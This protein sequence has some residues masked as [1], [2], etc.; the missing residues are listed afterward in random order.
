[1][2]LRLNQNEVNE[3]V[4]TIAETQTLETPTYLLAFRAESN[5][6]NYYSAIILPTK[7]LGVFTFF[8]LNLS[9]DFEL[10]N[11]GD[12]RYYIYEQTSTENLNPDLADNLLEQGIM[13]LI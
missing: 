4:V 3:I 11:E 7:T 9:I 8:S 12:F 10:P 6:D 13:Q 5:L 1:M 2:T